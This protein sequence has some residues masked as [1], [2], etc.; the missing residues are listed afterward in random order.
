MTK[1]ELDV[2]FP[3]YEI[4]GRTVRNRIPL[5]EPPKHRC[6]HCVHHL[7]ELFLSVVLSVW[8]LWT[9]GQWVFWLIGGAK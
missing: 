6:V 7:V 2:L 4:D 8:F 1:E 9:L 3:P 5:V